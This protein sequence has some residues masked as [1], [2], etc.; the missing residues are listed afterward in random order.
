MSLVHTI[1]IF[2]LFRQAGG[3]PRPIPASIQEAEAEGAAFPSE[4]PP[5]SLHRVFQRKAEGTAERKCVEFPVQYG[6]ARRSG[7]FVAGADI[8]NLTAG[9][10][11]KVSWTPLHDP[12]S[13]RSSLLVRGSRLD[14]P[15]ITSH[16]ASLTMSGHS[17]KTHPNTGATVAIPFIEIATDGF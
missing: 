17:R 13:V 2:A 5:P 3:D 10:E 4:A 15:G 12:A 11:G 9:R 16:F 14:Q 7:D 8:A 1:L 6:A